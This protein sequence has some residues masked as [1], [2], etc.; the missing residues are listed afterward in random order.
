MIV[1]GLSGAGTMTV[2][3]SAVRLL[4]P[5]FGA[6]VGVWTNVIGVILFALSIGYLLGAKLSR[7][8]DPLRMM[9]IALGAA[10]LFT[11]W[12]P[13]LA[14]PVAG[15]FLPAELALDEAASLLI[16]GS[17]AASMSLFLPAAMMLGCIGPLAV[18]AV[19]ASS[20][21]HAG[22]AGGRVLAASTIGSLA[23]TFGTTHT[24]LPH[25]GV[26]GTFQL[27][28]GVLIA[29]SVAF[30]LLS[31]KHRQM[32]S[33]IAADE[34]G[35]SGPGFAAK[36][37]LVLPWL[38]A[39]TGIGLA[40]YDLP[41]P[42]GGGVLLEELSSPYQALRV[43]ERYEGEERRRLLQANESLDSFQSIWQPRPGLLG[44][45]SYYDLFSLPAHWQ[46]AEDA[47]LSQWRVLILGLGAGTTVRVLDG[48]SPEGVEVRTIGIEIDPG[49]IELGKRHFDLVESERHAV[50]LGDARALLDGLEGSFDQIVIDCYANNMEIPAHL[51]TVEFY[52][53][54]LIKLRV[55][56]WLSVNAAG[57][58]FEDAVVRA[59]AAS[60]SQALIRDN[61]VR[62]D[63]LDA[64]TQGQAALFGTPTPVLA[65]RVP[66]SRNCI[67]IGRKGASVPEPASAAWRFESE[68]HV[69][70]LG[71][72]ELPE[73]W[74]W[75]DTNSLT[76]PTDDRCDIDLLQLESVLKGRRQWHTSE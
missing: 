3:L 11:A 49:V 27:A 2:E 1:V 5:W 55:G 26:T 76:A 51:A 13:S 52:E 50:V 15:Y 14:R 61:A 4:A 33:D 45:G 67:L 57:F 74:T 25:L 53:A 69:E 60:A 39:L 73:V 59:V 17:L 24:F 43:V 23:G 30:F 20:G 48:A 46:R 8:A 40:E 58:G 37:L 35:A 42:G 22:D 71:Q 31:R 38:F 65:L 21:G 18:E 63:S 10:A 12:L 34:G 75:I 64:G 41:K 72:L 66:F 36:S 62:A 70:L 16:W 54:V 19:Q 44:L 47:S 7:R 6:S 29:S 32:S 28:G 68:A 9:A 56:G